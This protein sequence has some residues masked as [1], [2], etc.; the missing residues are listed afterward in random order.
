MSDQDYIPDSLD[1]SEES[2]VYSELEH[3]KPISNKQNVS[4]IESTAEIQNGRQHQ[5][6]LTGKHSLLKDPVQV[7][8]VHSEKRTGNTE[9]K[10]LED[11]TRIGENP[12]VQSSNVSSSVNKKNYCYI[13]GKPQSKFTR[14]LKIHEKTNVDVA[15]VLALPKCSKERKTMLD[16]LRN[17]GNYEHSSGVLASGTGLLKLRHKP[18]EKYK[19]EDYVPCMYCPAMF[20][21][22]DL[23][24][25]VRN[26]L[27]KPVEDRAE[28]G[29]TR[30]LSLATM[31]NAAPC[32]Q[33][34]LG[35]WKLLTVMKDDD[36]SAAVRS[37]FC[38]LQL[39]QSF[40]NKHGQDPTKYDYIRQKL[41]EVGRLLLILRREFSIQTLED[42]VRP[43]NF[44][45]LIQAVKKVSGFND[46]ITPTRLQ[47]LLSSW[48]T[49]CK[50][51][52]TLYTAEL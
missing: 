6:N 11:S 27:S 7:S 30:V 40:F 18:K 25:H 45:V 26:C 38:T 17:K 32:Q 9:E 51:S 46:E 35:V 28:P 1:S 23:W 8:D 16:K 52:V 37:D 22:R 34:S 42:A 50:R 14:H 20:L 39:A 5:E 33:I 41:R 19:S 3:P 44:K 43:A 29:R 24:R 21:R 2:A 4:C 48:V 10:S 49:H 12:C 47:A 13:C 15:R 36:I 31:S